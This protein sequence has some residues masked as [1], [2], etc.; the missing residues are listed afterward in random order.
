MFGP[1]C[2]QLQED[3]AQA[4]RARGKS[5]LLQQIDELLQLP[6]APQ[7]DL[8]DLQRQERGSRAEEGQGTPSLSS[9]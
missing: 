3:C 4:E 5:R 6:W 8:C 2:G 9:G 1:G 7:Q